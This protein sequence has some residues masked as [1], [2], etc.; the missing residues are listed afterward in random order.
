[1]MRVQGVSILF[2]SQMTNKLYTS[3]SHHLGFWRHNRQDEKA[4]I[5]ST[6]SARLLCVPT[7]MPIHVNLLMDLD[8]SVPI[9]QTPLTEPLLVVERTIVSWEVSGQ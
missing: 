4:V 9:D 2:V 5:K 8:S 1:M 6:Y 3:F 7:H